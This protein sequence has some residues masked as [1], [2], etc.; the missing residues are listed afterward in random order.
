MI[1]GSGSRARVADLVA[2]ARVA[3]DPTGALVERLLA[4]VLA[5]GVGLLVWVL[6]GSVARGLELP[7]V[8]RMATAVNIGPPPRCARV[9]S[10]HLPGAD[11]RMWADQMV[12]AGEAVPA[13]VAVVDVG[14]PAVADGDHVGQELADRRGD[15]VAVAG[16]P[17][18]QPQAVHRRR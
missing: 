1:S 17:G 18:A 14:V 13:E 15:L 12:M 16:E 11:V 2:A 9:C 6:L 10:A 4:V 3:A 8:R 7:V 5:A